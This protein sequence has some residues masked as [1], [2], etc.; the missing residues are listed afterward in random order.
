MI[1]LF[2]L[3]YIVFG[4]K[5]IEYQNKEIFTELPVKLNLPIGHGFLL[6]LNSSIALV[7]LDG[8][9]LSELKWRVD[10][11]K[12]ISECKNIVRTSKIDCFNLVRVIFPTSEDSSN[13][14]IACGSYAYMTQLESLE[15]IFD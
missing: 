4:I 13:E 12:I 15:N 8:S 10:N 2:L 11:P 5:P 3:P 6:G 14:F 9:I 1:W 7:G